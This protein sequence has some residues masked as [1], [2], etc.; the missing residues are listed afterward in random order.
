M[1]HV[2]K[3]LERQAD[4]LEQLV[5]ERTKELVEEK[6]RSELLLHRLLPKFNFKFLNSLIVGSHTVCIPV[7]RGMLVSVS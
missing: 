5:E 6:K 7:I 3:L 2:F 4:R 1:D